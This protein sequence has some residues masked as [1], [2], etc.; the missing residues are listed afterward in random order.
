M[1][2]ERAKAPMGCIRRHGKR[3]FYVRSPSSWN[4]KSCN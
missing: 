1:Y 2:K 4:C 3:C